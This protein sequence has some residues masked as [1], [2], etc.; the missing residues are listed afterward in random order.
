MS[1]EHRSNVSAE[2]IPNTIKIVSTIILVLF[3]LYFFVPGFF[4]RLFTS[5]AHPF[6]TI[7]KE[8]SLPTVE[9]QNTIISQLQKENAYLQTVLLRNA[10]SSPFLLAPIIKKPPF[11]AYDSYIVDVGK[12]DAV[13]VGNRVYAVGNVLLGEVVE[14]NGSFAKVKLYSSYG[15]KFDVSIGNNNIQTIATGQGG[16]SFQSILP[17]DVK[18]Q[19]DDVVTIP[20]L[21]VSIFGIVR[22]V[23][24]QPARAFSTIFFSQPVNIY[25][26]KWVLINTHEL[27]SQ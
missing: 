14:K 25:E 12:T 21:Q 9:L 20:E 16:G 15:E 22:S 27:K 24:I 13:K 10:S 4:P 17:K 23:D 5:I 26:Q 7:T 3:L 6:W 19:V 18:I 2:G 1:Y 8:D 11:S